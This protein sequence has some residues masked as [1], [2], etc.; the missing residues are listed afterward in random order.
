MLVEK[1]PYA[2]HLHATQMRCFVLTTVPPHFSEAGRPAEWPGPT[3]LSPY[4]RSRIPSP[5]GPQPV[6][7][8]AVSVALAS[9][10]WPRRRAVG[11]P[12]QQAGNT[13]PHAVPG[14][15]ADAPSAVPAV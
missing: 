12:W 15:P 14:E 13:G 6:A 4:L 10:P 1:Q 5:T 8:T 2:A 11:L 3:P 9:Q 7:L